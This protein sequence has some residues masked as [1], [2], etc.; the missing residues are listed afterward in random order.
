MKAKAIAA[1]MALCLGLSGCG[2]HALYGDHANGVSADELALIYVA[3]I[4][5]R[6]GQQL[7][8]FLVTNLNP[9]GQ[10]SQPIYALNVSLGVASTGVG[11]SRDNTTSRT[12]ITT[13]ATYTLVDSASG[14]AV[15][16]AVS[17]ATDAYDVLLSDYATLVSRD[18]AVN[19]A[20]REVSDDIRT[21]LAV[22]FQNRKAKGRTAT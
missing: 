7:R 10:P 16:S 3:G 6:P 5:D 8:N 13:T 18:D 22:Y 2:Y 20:L 12:S 15:F 4:P 1:L 21:R 19:R 11:L 17:R 9:S 14:K